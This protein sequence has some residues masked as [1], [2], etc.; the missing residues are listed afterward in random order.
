[1]KKMT[2]LISVLFASLAAVGC[3]K[4]LDNS[5]FIEDYVYPDEPSEVPG[6]DTEPDVVG[7][8]Q[9]KVISFNMRTGSAD[10]NTQNAW[11]IRKEGIPAMMTKENPTVMGV[12]EAL[13]YQISYV[14]D[15]VPGYDYY[16]VGRDNGGSSGETM[17]IFYKTDVVELGDHGTFWLSET[18]DVPSDGWDAAYRRTATWAFFT[19]KATG[20]TFFYIN[21]HLDNEGSEAREQ[22]IILIC[23]KLG[24]LNPE[25]YPS[26]LTADFNSDTS[27]AI[28]DPLK[29]V[30]QDARATAPETDQFG[31]F[32]G[33]G[34]TT[35]TID[36]IFYSGFTPVSYHTIMD[37]W[38]GVQY[39]S[40][41]YPISAVLEFE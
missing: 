36:H 10:A 34:T 40:D 15:N 31:T 1:M 6:D 4:T 12:Q 19:V 35:S 13:S 39:L 37:R 8:N 17:A 25:G 3:S 32:N 23:E 2:I 20:E 33:W 24:E 38:N 41:H 11:D 7:E 14:K 27:N 28:F 18:P 5:H 30:M 16:G 22:S 26:I 29:E 21:T 9:I